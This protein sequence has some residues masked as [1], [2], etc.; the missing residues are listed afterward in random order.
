MALRLVFDFAFLAA[1]AGYYFGCSTQRQAMAKAS[2]S[3]RALSRPGQAEVGRAVRGGRAVHDAAL[4]SVAV[5]WAEALQFPCRWRTVFL[6]C[7]IGLRAA[8][9]LVDMALAQWRAAAVSLLWMDA[10]ALALAL[11]GRLRARAPAAEEAN[12]RLLAGVG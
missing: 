5:Q 1:A 8:A 11:F 7:L 9:A 12:R 10:L 4:A 6:W 3:L 2:R